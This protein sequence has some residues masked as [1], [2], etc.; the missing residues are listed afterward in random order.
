[1]QRGCTSETIF[2]LNQNPLQTKN[3]NPKFE[4]D[5]KLIKLSISKW[6]KLLIILECLFNKDDHLQS[7][8]NIVNEFFADA[9][10]IDS[11]DACETQI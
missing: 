7:S 5:L 4:I 1:M 2:N 3:L 11:V 9:V 8:M 6:M 10:G